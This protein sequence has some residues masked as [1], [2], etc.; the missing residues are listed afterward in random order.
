M[1]ISYISKNLRSQL[2]CILKK[3]ECNKIVLRRMLRTFFF[4]SKQLDILRTWSIIKSLQIILVLLVM[5]ILTYTHCKI[6][7][8]TLLVACFALVCYII[9]DQFITLKQQY[10]DLRI[11]CSMN[12]EKPQPTSSSAD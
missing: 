6:I 2:S 8:L 7:S 12:D 9:A 1:R 5:S 10:E 4:I 3:R 11:S